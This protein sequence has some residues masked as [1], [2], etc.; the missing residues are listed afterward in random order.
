M[1][2]WWGEQYQDLLNKGLDMIWQDMTDPAVVRSCDSYAPYK[3][4]PL[5]VKMTDWRDGRKKANAKIH[6]AFAISLIQA[7]YEGLTKIKQ[8]L[9]DGHYNKNKRNF[10]IARGGY[11]GVHR[12]AANWTG[13]SAS[14]W[15]F[16]QINIPEVLNW[17]M[18]GQALSGCDI[19]GFGNGSD[20]P[21][22]GTVVGSGEIK[23]GQISGE[24]LARWMTMGAFLPWYRN[25][26][27]GYTKAYQE[28]YKYD[29]YVTDACRKYIEIR[30]KL[31]QL[32][33]DAM[34]E[35]TQ[36]GMPIC[37]ALFLNDPQDQN[38]YKDPFVKYR[39]SDEFFVGR[40]LL[41]APMVYQNTQERDIYLPAGSNWYVYTDNI[42][43]ITEPTPGG[44]SYHWHDITLNLVPIYVREGTIIPVRE[45]EQWVGQLNSQG[46]PNPITYSIYPGKSAYPD[47]DNS[48]VCYE[49]DGISTA[50]EN[51]KVYRITKIA[52][53]DGING[54]TIT[55][56]RE[57]DNYKPQLE[58]FYYVSLL[59]NHSSPTSVTVNG[60]TIGQV[61]VGNDNQNADALSNSKSDAYYYSL[62]LQTT[63]IKIFDDKHSQTAIINV[64]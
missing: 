11:A 51:E 33:Y 37:R 44:K 24:L 46:K 47:I 25:H 49:D 28:P 35:Y 64:Q 1:Q 60:K 59:G 15:D 63:F 38:L 32:F 2:K 19:G 16:L 54:K 30:Y 56:S 4:L 13:D 5:N 31:L 18:S 7:T 10:I 26:Y 6:N 39:L 43:P 61:Q 53:Q 8:S 27:N 42:R 34:Y 48:Y 57:Y 40:D 58:N 50:A 55:V 52:H 41:V 3:T 29:S 45:L 36:T 14:S 20:D 22:S 17:G 21:N 62:S 9:P 12:Y 23:D